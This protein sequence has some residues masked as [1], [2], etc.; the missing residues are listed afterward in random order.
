MKWQEID[1]APK[2]DGPVLT[3]HHLEPTFAVFAQPDGEKKGNYCWCTFY[4]ER[5]W[6]MVYD[7]MY[8]Q[9]TFWLDVTPPEE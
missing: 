6:G 4:D 9:P 3:W 2:Y 1:T 7:R 5:S 8:P